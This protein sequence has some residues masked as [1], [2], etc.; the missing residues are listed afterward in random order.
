MHIPEDVPLP[1]NIK[2]ANISKAFRLKLVIS[3]DNIF[4]SKFSTHEWHGVEKNHLC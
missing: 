2:S 4:V 3:L 1:I